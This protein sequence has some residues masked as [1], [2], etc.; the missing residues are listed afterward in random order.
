MTI[1]FVNALDTLNTENDD[2]HLLFERTI[3]NYLKTC[4][5]MCIYEM[6]IKIGCSKFT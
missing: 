1:S 4:F 5:K 6:P 3:Y 2:I